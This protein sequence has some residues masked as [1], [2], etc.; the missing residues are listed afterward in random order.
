MNKI[1]KTLFTLSLPSLL[2]A[3]FSQ[4]PEGIAPAQPANTTVRMDFEHRP[5]PEIPLPNDIATRFDPESPTKRRINASM[6]ASTRHESIIRQQIDEIDGW[7]ALQPIS[8]P[9]TR[10]LDVTSVLNGHR[11]ADYDFSNDVIYVIDVTEGSPDYGKPV[12]LDLGNGNYPVILEVPDLYWDNDPRVSTISMLYEDTDE[13]LNG[14]GVLDPG[15]DTDAD[16]T[17]DTPNWLPGHD[18]AP[19]DLAGR[20]DALMTFYEKETNTLIARPMEPL[21]ERTTY[22]VVVTRRLLDVDGEPVGSP[23]EWVHHLA[24]TEDLRPLPEVL[25]QGLGLDDVAFAFTF[26][27]QSTT[28]G[29]VAVRDGLYGHGVQGHLSSVA[30]EVSKIYPLRDAGSNRHLLHGETWLKSLKDIGPIL[31]NLDEETEYAKLMFDGMSYVDY[32]A[33]G[34][35]ES[36]QL[37]P[38]EGEDGEMLPYDAQIWP[39]DLD[40]KPAPMRSETVHFTVVVPRKEISARG[41]GKSPPVLIMGH[42]YTSSRFE[43]MSFASYFARHGVTVIA[44]D[45]PS[46]GLSVKETEVE[47]AYGILNRNGAGTAASALF[48]DRARDHN[49]DTRVDSG[50][51]FWSAYMLHTRDNVRQFALD[52]FQLIRMIRTFDGEKRWSYDT[53]GDGTIDIDQLAG[54]FDGDGV[55]DVSADAPLY[56]LGGSLGGMMSILVGS[57]EPEVDAIV[58]IAGGGGLSNLGLRSKQGGVPEAFILRAV[59]PLVLATIGERGTDLEFVV[60]SAND[61]E[62]LHFATIESGISPGDTMLVENLMNQELGCGLLS[63]DGRTRAPIASDVADPLRVTFYAGD[64]LVPGGEC[65]LRADAVALHTVDTVEIGIEFEG[66]FITRGEPLRALTEG[67]GL[68]RA[69]PELRRLQ[70]FAQ[71]ALD[72]ADPAIYARHLQREPLTYPGTGETTGAHALMIFTLGDMSVPVSGGMSVARAAGLLDY[73]NVDDRYGVPPNQLLIDNYIA[74]SVHTLKRFTNDAGGGVHIDIENFADGDDAWTSEGQPRLA[75]PLRLGVGETD[76]LGGAS[77]ALFPLTNP[78]GMHGFDFPG[79]R[80]DEAREAC[81]DAC[82][83][84]EPG[85]PCECNELTQFDEAQ[86]VVNM[87]LRYVLSGAKE[88]TLDRCMAYG[89]CPDVPSVLPARQGAELP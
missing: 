68:R 85:D 83:I 58:P 16:G 4:A 75:Q 19:D 55:L 50:A 49:N 56:M 1:N 3:C 22:A 61:F 79:V 42:G 34:T 15:E 23:Y 21:R 20:A 44:I 82:E 46:H 28:A 36:P 71:V 52:Y 2:V 39:P 72:P 54:D 66:E 60:P 45:G 89:D 8:V 47:L 70:S 48:T 9:F 53:D 37:F 10:P 25:P 24:Q 33:M 87:S 31:M 27:T 65:D 11:D 18:P 73:T 77:A 5:L 12:A 57:L 67:L 76:R 14:N 86:F 69:H 43:A 7:G 29:M 26:T 40:T 59:S 35:F 84:F 38:I 41:E 80:A 62:Q 74:E 30:P 13:D 81:W 88:I 32:F 78:E 51:D 63:A 17:L 64:A 6:V